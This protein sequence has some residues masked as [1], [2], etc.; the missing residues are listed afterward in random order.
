[1]LLKGIFLS[2]LWQP[3][4]S[5]ERN[6]LCKFGREY[7]EEQFYEIILNDFLSGALPTRLFSGAEPFMQI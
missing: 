3:F 1:M 7:Q 2:E 4:Y 5:V 6:H